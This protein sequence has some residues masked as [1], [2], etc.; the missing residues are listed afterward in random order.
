MTECASRTW[1]WCNVVFWARASMLLVTSLRF[2]GTPVQSLPIIYHHTT[3][4]TDTFL[5][6]VPIISPIPM[7]IARNRE[8]HSAFSVLMAERAA[9]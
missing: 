4:R 9:R 5:E 3:V 2:E 6:W 8:T 7:G 1:W